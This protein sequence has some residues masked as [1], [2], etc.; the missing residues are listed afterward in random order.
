MMLKWLLMSIFL[1]SSSVVCWVGSQVETI[2][3][4]KAENE[5]LCGECLQCA[6]LICT[7]MA[8]SNHESELRCCRCDAGG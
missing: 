2:F 6:P 5:V 3:K 7:S 4:T 8:L 1:M